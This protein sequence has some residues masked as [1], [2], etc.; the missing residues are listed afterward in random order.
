MNTGGAGTVD[1]LAAE[2]LAAAERGEAPD[3]VGWLARHPAHAAE[4]AEFLADL[5]RFAPFLGLSDLPPDLDRTSVFR[6]GGRTRPEIL[7]GDVFGG[8]ELVE[9]IGA[10]GMGLVFRAAVVGTTLIVA[11]KRLDPGLGGDEARRFREEVEAAAALDH[12]NIVK[13]YHIG[14]YAGRPYFTM[15]L[16]EGGSLDRHVDRFRGVPRAAADLV[17]KVARAVHH[18]HQR[19]IVHRDLK[20]SNILL[21][22][23]GAPHVADFGLAARLDA[24]DPAGPAGSL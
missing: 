9:Q 17:L 11:L 12:P 13:V 20:P 10:G 6:P 22:G 7:P 14:E 4:L 2:F 5:G 16:L 15:P 3:P 21:D 23:G 1:E 18:A 19:R 24:A 8:Y